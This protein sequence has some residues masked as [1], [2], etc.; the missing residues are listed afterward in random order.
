MLEMSACWLDKIDQVAATVLEHGSR[1][2]AHCLWLTPEPHATKL[3]P[4]HIFV[5]VFCDECSRRNPSLEQSFL[6]NTR[7]LKSDWL[8][9]EL[10]PFHP[11]RGWKGKPAILP[12]W[13]IGHLREAKNRGVDPQ[14]TTTDTKVHNVSTFFAFLVA[15]I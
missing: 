6:V 1:D 8:Q 13:Y 10:N 12:H 14:F 4:I 7:R 2:G 15:L 9:Y 5:K 11:V 3:Q